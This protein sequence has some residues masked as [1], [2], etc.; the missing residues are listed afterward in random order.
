MS[1]QEIAR[2]KAATSI[3]ALIGETLPLKRESQ[4]FI[5]ACPFHAEK[6][7]SFIV[8]PDHFHCFGCG[9]HG[10]VF[11]WLMQAHGMTIPE[12]VRHLGGGN[13]RRLAAV[14]SLSPAPSVG[15]VAVSRPDFALCKVVGTDASN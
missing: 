8:Y 1:G 12:A 5:A 4:L 6:T 2:V 11:T 3:V 14:Q 7:P 13:S 15:Q 10:D 9:A